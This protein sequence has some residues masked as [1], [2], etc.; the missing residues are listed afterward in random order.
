MDKDI[1]WVGIDAHTKTLQ[2][3]VFRR[4][5]RGQRVEI[6]HDLKAVQRLA[7]KL[8]RLAAGGELRCCY[9]PGPCGYALKR[10]LSRR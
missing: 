6:A 9:E 1:T 10:Q 4:Q 7:S 5:E 8:V 3:A 2:S